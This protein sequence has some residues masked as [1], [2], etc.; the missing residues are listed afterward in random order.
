MLFLT[1]QTWGVF[2]S[3]MIMSTFTFAR[4]MSYLTPNYLRLEV[5]SLCSDEKQ[6][7]LGYNIQILQ[8]F[9][10]LYYGMKNL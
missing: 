9:S 10:T 8:F 4:N 1:Y 6:A 2:M 5:K 7:I 3:Q